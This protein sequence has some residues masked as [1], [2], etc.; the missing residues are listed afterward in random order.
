[1]CFG[2]KICIMFTHLFC[3]IIVAPR[4]YCNP[5]GTFCIILCTHSIR[6]LCSKVTL[7]VKLILF[8]L[9]FVFFF[10]WYRLR[11]RAKTSQPNK[12]NERNTNNTLNTEFEAHTMVLG[13]R[14][15][16]FFVIC[17]CFVNRT[18]FSATNPNASFD[19]K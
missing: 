1:M 8:Y 9:F 6:F 16:L 19:Y 11:W 2:P 7:T 15:L 12:L 17:A 14:C 4:K 18:L 13:Q 10:F 3:E 5:S